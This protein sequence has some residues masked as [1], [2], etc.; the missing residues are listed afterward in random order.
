MGKNHD[1]QK[2]DITCHKTIPQKPA[3]TKST[4]VQLLFNITRILAL[5]YRT[6]STRKT[7]Y[8]R[9][10]VK[11]ELKLLDFYTVQICSFPLLWGFSAPHYA[12]A[13]L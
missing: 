11:F 4:K 10:G 6:E 7:L 3:K 8:Y 12:I 5:F 2:R 13:L 9:K 1:I